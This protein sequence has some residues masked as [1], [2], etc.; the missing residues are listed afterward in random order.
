MDLF[1][2]LWYCGGFL[3]S[4][5]SLVLTKPGVTAIF[6]NK[7]WLQNKLGNLSLRQRPAAI[8]WT[9]RQDTQESAVAIGGYC[10]PLSMEAEG[11]PLLEATTNQ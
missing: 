11:S 2:S 1:Q 8:N 7:E 4:V 9:D 6:F 5:K 10:E 3:V